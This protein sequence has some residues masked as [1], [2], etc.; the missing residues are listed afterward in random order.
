M[1]TF[2]EKKTKCC[3]RVDIWVDTFCKI[4]AFSPLPYGQKEGLNLWKWAFKGWGYSVVLLGVVFGGI[5]ADCLVY[6]GFG[7]FSLGLIGLLG[8]IGR[9]T[10]FFGGF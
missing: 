3:E 7:G 9:V 6:R 2:R 5:L 4:L 8:I 10:R 1:D